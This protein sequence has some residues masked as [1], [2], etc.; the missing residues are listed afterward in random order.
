MMR[1]EYHINIPM[2]EARWAVL[3]HAL[4]GHYPRFETG[5]RCDS[6]S[7]RRKY[8]MRILTINTRKIVDDEVELMDWDVVTMSP[9]EDEV[10]TATVH[11]HGGLYLKLT[12]PKEV[13]P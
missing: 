3:G 6:I 7:I 11:R 13:R 5:R 8:K 12:F 9:Y 1:P 2:S 4:R 10:L